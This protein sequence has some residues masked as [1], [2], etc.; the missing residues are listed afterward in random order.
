MDPVNMCVSHVFVFNWYVKCVAEKRLVT[1]T[2]NM[3]TTDE[4]VLLKS[5]HKWL[6]V[7]CIKEQLSVIFLCVCREFCTQC[8]NIISPNGKTYVVSR[9]F[10][11]SVRSSLCLTQGQIAKILCGYGGT[12]WRG[13]LRHCATNRKVEG[14]ITD[15]ITWIFQWLN[16]FGRIVALGSTQPLTEKS[17]RNPC[18]G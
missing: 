13:W 16:S 8:V 12:R 2:T 9:S 18:W 7:C 17:T 1:S 3:D 6:E 15:E 14:S 10:S 11:H 5:M 4:W